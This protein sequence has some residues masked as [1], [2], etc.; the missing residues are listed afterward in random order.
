VSKGALPLACAALLTAVSAACGAAPNPRPDVVLIT[1]DTL[2]A[3]A[4][5]FMG[6]AEAAT[7]TLDRLAATGRVFTDAHAHNV[8]T[9]PSHVNLLTG[10]YPFQHGVRDNEGFRLPDS[11]PTLATLLRD[12]GYATGAVVGA[13]PLDSE[14]GLARGFDS[15]DDRLPK[16]SRAREFVMPERS[17]REVVDLGRRWWA[18]N[19]AKPRFLWLHLYDPHAPYLPP[20]PFASRFAKKPYAGEV[21]AVDSYLATF[22]APFLDGKEREAL[23][24]FTSDHGEALGEHGELTHGLF[25]YEPTLKV[26]LV[27]WGSGV[28]AGRDARAAGHV[29]VVPTVLARLGLEAPAASG[30]GRHLRRSGR[31][32]LATASPSGDERLYFEAL[33][34]TLNRGWA[35]LRGFIEGGRKYISLPLPEL[36]DLKGD[37][38]ERDNAYVREKASADAVLNHLPRESQWPPQAGNETPEATKALLALGYVGGGTAVGAPKTVA[39]GPADDP[40]NTIA[41]DRKIQAFIEA[42]QG[43]ALERALALGKEIVTERPKMP[44]GHSL[45]AQ[46]LLEA[47]RVDE[48]LRVMSAARSASTATEPTLRQLGLTLSEVGR[49]PEALEVLKPLAERGVVANRNAYAGVLSE[50]GRQDEAERELRAILTADPEE[51]KALEQ[52]GLVAL[53]RQRFAEAKVWCEKALAVNREL[54]LAWNYIGVAE[55]QSNRR[56]AAVEAWKRAVELDPELIDA[57]WNLGTTAADLGM[58]DEASRA[59]RAFVERASPERYAKDIARARE[60]LARFGSGR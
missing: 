6:N 33:S 12:A 39:Y 29:D 38:R 19:S 42:Y 16:G 11:V 51:P 25:A 10:L 56:P 34:T 17:G 50:A 8:V 30:A 13:F 3:D 58:K 4:L 54:P 22:L 24:V 1:I 44:L 48:A 52:M 18:A 60:Y 41:L 53:R 35:P 9:L 27:L 45:Y 23:V 49:Y 43:H 36:Y 21:A 37:P 7:P 20:E 59:L 15:Y 28:A 31:S 47:G 32:L 57:L 55:A 2:R 5:G 26:P 46:A 14:F 40:K